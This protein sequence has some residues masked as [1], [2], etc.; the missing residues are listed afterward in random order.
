MNNT[1]CR[2]VVVERFGELALR[3]EGRVFWERC[4]LGGLSQVLRKD[5]GENAHTPLISSHYC[6]SRNIPLRYCR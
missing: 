4:G 2:H 5:P 1:P 6:S 3:L